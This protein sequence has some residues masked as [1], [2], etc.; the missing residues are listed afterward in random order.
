MLVIF[1]FLSSFSMV[2]KHFFSGITTLGLRTSGEF[3]AS[4]GT[5][6]GFSNGFVYLWPY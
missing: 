2:A 5:G 1:C 6:L 3:R 4:Y